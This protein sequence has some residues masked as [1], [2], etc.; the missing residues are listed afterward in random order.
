MV[1]RKTSKPIV[2]KEEASEERVVAPLKPMYFGLQ[3][4]QYGMYS[5]QTPSLVDKKTLEDSRFWAFLAQ[6][7]KIGDEVRVVAQDC[8][9]RAVLMCTYSHGTDAR[10]KVVEYCALEE[11]DY[12]ALTGGAAEYNV[13][14]KGL[15]GW[16]IIKDDGTVIEADLPSQGKALQKLEEYL[17][18]LAA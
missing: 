13:E 7:L 4:H 8:T 11:V 17:K 10:M 15:Q 3:T 6:R 18:A 12:A 5:A 1:K 16:C 14:L 9:F 2:V